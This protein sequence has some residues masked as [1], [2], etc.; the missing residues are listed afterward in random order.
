MHG[1]ST[2]GVKLR[3][4][5]L[6]TTPMTLLQNLLTIPSP[7]DLHIGHE[8]ITRNVNDLEFYEVEVSEH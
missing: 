6:L 5:T 4:R 3:D 1:L 2:F 8:T 7:H